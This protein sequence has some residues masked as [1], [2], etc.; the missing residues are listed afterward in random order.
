[1]L[2][3]VD[4]AVLYSKIHIHFRG[5]GKAML[6]EL[7]VH[8]NTPGNIIPPSRAYL[9]MNESFLCHGSTVNGPLVLLLIECLNDL[10][11]TIKSGV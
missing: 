6:S 1:M 5:Q 8:T 11:S 9:Y 10:V 3:G 2:G 7:L 4:F